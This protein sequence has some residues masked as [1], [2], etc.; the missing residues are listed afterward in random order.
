MISPISL[1][2]SQHRVKSFL[3]NSILLWKQ[4]INNE[5][6]N[7]LILRPNNLMLASISQS[8]PVVVTTLQN[9]REKLH[10]SVLIMS[11]SCEKSVSLSLC[12]KLDFLST[13][14]CICCC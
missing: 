1:F 7:K 10:L 5:H 12:N 14:A 3:Q 4:R 13:P 2:P 9:S 11:P 6:F 8:L